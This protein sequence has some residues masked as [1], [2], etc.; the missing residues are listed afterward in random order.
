M[1]ASADHAEWAASPSP[2]ADGGKRDLK[3]TFGPVYDHNVG[4]LRTVND[5]CFPLA[6]ADKFYKDVLHTPEEFT[7]YGAW[8]SAPSFPRSPLGAHP[9]PVP[10]AAYSHGFVIGAVCSRIEPSV[11]PG[12][13][14][15]LYIM[16]LGV[17]PAYRRRGIA[18][19]LL[20]RVL[21]NVKAFP[22]IGEITL[23]R[24][25]AA[26]YGRGRASLTSRFSLLASSCS[27]YG[28]PTTR[29]SSSTRRSASRRRAPSRT[30]TG[31]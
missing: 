19:K 25:R 9:L 17:L 27:T 26:A 20:Q 8:A 23:V 18:G 6:Y 14:K 11:E 16:T 24:V 30:T 3:I 1:V 15:R 31:D 13:P 4:M 28:R 2:W 21:D 12:G 7:C 5:V 29:R 22:Q 10:R